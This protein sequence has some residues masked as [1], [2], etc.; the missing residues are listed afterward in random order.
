MVMKG[1][2]EISNSLTFALLGGG[3]GVWTQ[4]CGFREWQENG[5]A[6]RLAPPGFF[7]YVYLL[8]LNYNARTL[9]AQHRFQL[10][11]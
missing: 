11:F 4:P 2:K 10:L 5:G 3:G 7:T 8:E 1:T 6:A 9:S